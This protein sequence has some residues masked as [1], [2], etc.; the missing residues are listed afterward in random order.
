MSNE[1]H[2]YIQ[3]MLREKLKQ[4]SDIS[5]TFK[6]YSI[7]VDSMALDP[8]YEAL[9]GEAVVKAQTLLPKGLGLVKKP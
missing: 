3:N 9:I 5:E 2:A 4:A 8:G 6:I 1:N 7:A